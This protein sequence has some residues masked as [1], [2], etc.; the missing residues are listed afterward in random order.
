[1]RK[2]NSRSPA[3]PKT[4]PKY[5]SWLRRTVGTRDIRIQNESLTVNQA[6]GTIS[7]HFNMPMSYK[8]PRARKKPDPKYIERYAVWVV[9]E[10]VRDAMVMSLTDNAMHKEAG[11]HTAYWILRRARAMMGIL[12]VQGGVLEASTDCTWDRVVWTGGKNRV[13]ITNYFTF[14]MEYYGAYVDAGRGGARKS[15]Y[16]TDEG[17]SEFYAALRE[18]VERKLNVG[19]DGGEI[20]RV[21]RAI[22]DS[23]NEHG[24][25]TTPDYW[26]AST[27]IQLVRLEVLYSVMDDEIDILL[28]KNIEK[29][30]DVKLREHFGD[31]YKGEGTIS[32]S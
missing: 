29:E 27:L 8:M 17:V 13:D 22:Y 1:M 30:I 6:D 25:V 32:I 23:I 28:D 2:R 11:V 15:G 19:P 20:D 10:A 4:V 31:R 16:M 24:P 26:F 3:Y 9:T 18:W 5:G 7:L 12:G 21:T 14:R